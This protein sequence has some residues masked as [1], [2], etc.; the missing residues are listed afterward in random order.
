M[1]RCKFVVAGMLAA[2]VLPLRPA[3]AQSYEAQVLELVNLAR[4]DNGQLPPMK[5][6][7][8]LDAAAENHSAAMAARNFFMHCDPDTQSLPWD[9]MAA[10]GYAWQAAAENI[11]AGYSS[12]QSAMSGWM[13][14]A[15]HRANILGGYRE[16]G[17]G[18]VS[19]NDGAATRTL[20]GSGCTPNATG[21]AYTSYWTQ[22]FGSDGT[23]PLVIDREAYRTGTCDVALY[24]YA[25]G[26]TTQMRFSNDGQT[27]S[28]WRA[29]AA[30]TTWRVAGA[31][32]AVATVQ[33]E[34]RG[35][36]ART[37]SDSI[38]LGVACSAGGGEPPVFA[39]S[40]E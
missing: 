11:G 33:V 22:N 12:P 9:R 35:S 26:G 29:Y 14:S 1:I 13:N 31:N 23:Y 2:G 16:I 15:G 36:G 5:G 19:D 32:G 38:V 28:A 25:P 37:A 30:N 8:V 34:T 3:L 21:G 39:S 18:Y 4:W 27:W 20:N 17:V 40:F 7:A 6:S 24:V 10:A